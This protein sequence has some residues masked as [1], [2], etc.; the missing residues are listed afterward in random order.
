MLAREEGVLVPSANLARQ[1][2]AEV[3]LVPSL[4]RG[5]LGMD[6][7]GGRWVLTPEVSRRKVAALRALDEMGRIAR[8]I[9]VMRHLR[10]P[11][12]NRE[13]GYWVHALQSLRRDGLVLN[14]GRGY[15]ALASWGTW[16]ESGSLSEAR[17]AMVVRTLRG[18][19][20]PMTTSELL[21]AFCTREDGALITVSKDPQLSLEWL[22]R[23][24][25]TEP[26]SPII[27]SYRPGSLFGL[28]ALKEWGERAS[29]ERIAKEMQVFSITDRGT[30]GR[31]SL[32]IIVQALESLGRPSTVR[33]VAGHLEMLGLVSR[34]DLKRE[35][36]RWVEGVVGDHKRRSGDSPFERP[37]KNLLSLPAWREAAEIEA[38]L[39]LHVCT[40][41]RQWL[42]REDFYGK[43]RDGR[44]FGQCKACYGEHIS[45]SRK[46]PEKKAAIRE[47]YMARALAYS[48]SKAM[49]EVLRAG[50]GSKG[51]KPWEGLV[52]YTTEDLRQH[53]ESLFH[54]GMSWDNYGRI[55]GGSVLG[56]WHLDHVRPMA[57]F[58]PV[59]SPEDPIFQEMFALSN[60]APEWG[61]DNLSKSSFWQGRKWTYR[62]WVDI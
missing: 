33:E 29:S 42:P 48:V 23:E 53:V 41:C 22:L 8:A 2:I 39:P 15:Y 38:G 7:H 46:S 20:H 59:S 19:G 51:R 14:L 54:D 50:G 5:E 21:E 26:T 37:R 43:G 6:G 35:P 52:G 60:L 17:M 12:G 9:D 61:G 36:H 57:S 27:M 16:S 4:T 40:D 13:R 1:R 34:I 24:S 45:E 30:D 11:E 10:R 47:R 32:S 55:K 44:I 49:S 58:P 25:R 31:S 62:D 18:E 28:V 56:G 3:I